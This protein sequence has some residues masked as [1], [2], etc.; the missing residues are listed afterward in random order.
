MY[1][2]YTHPRQAFHPVHHRCLHSYT[3]EWLQPNPQSPTWVGVHSARA[4]HYVAA[5][6]ERGLLQPLLGMSMSHT[7]RREV[8]YGTRSRVDF[9]LQE[10]KCSTYVEVKSVTLTQQERDVTVAVFPDTVSTRAQ[11]HARE[12]TALLCTKAS[13][14]EQGKRRRVEG[15][16]RRAVMLFVVQRDD[17]QE[18]APCKAKDPAYAALCVQAAAAG[19]QLVAVAI[20]LNEE[21][22]VEYVR[23]LPVVDV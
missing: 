9:V 2:A 14:E 17:A 18:F 21:D 12:L 7:T 5:M 3:L 13:A 23:E 20:R 4:N 10:G 15:K 1:T 16:A 11:Q 6:L 22:A 19:V 8:P